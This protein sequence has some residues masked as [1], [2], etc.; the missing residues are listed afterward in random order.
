MVTFGPKCL[1]Q[2]SSKFCDCPNLAQ[3]GPDFELRWTTHCDSTI[4]TVN[5]RKTQNKK[6]FKQKLWSTNGDSSH[7][8]LLTLRNF[9]IIGSGL[10]KIHDMFKHMCDREFVCFIF[11]YTYVSVCRS[12]RSFVN[13]TTDDVSGW[14]WK[15]N[16]ELREIRV[17]SLRNICLCHFSDH[18]ILYIG[19]WTR[20]RVSESCTM[21]NS[22]TN[23]YIYTYIYLE[24]QQQH[25]SNMLVWFCFE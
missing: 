3:T 19:C 15:R 25:I 9:N 4:Y 18:T 13:E 11:P 5:S 12:V 8:S 10:A 23:I 16:P 20:H 2:K 22:N 14:E 17:E 1:N 24:K 6:R 21:F 7:R